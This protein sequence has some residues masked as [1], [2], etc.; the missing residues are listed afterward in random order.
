MFNQAVSPAVYDE[1]TTEKNCVRFT[2]VEVTMAFL[3]KAARFGDISKENISRS[4]RIADINPRYE[5]YSPE[6]Q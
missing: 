6:Y 1:G 5:P 2:C 3:T 4:T